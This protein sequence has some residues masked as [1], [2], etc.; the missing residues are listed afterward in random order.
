ML[1]QGVRLPGVMTCIMLYCAVF[2][3]A[4]FG[5]VIESSGETQVQP[6]LLL[7][8]FPGVLAGLTSREAPLGVALCGAV[9]ATPL[10]LLLLHTHFILQSGF[11][12][13]FA[14]HA[15]ALFWCGSGALV[16]MLWRAMFSPR[17]HS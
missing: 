17:R 7:F 10:C 1:L 4:R 3:I 15:S 14:W 11:W 6:G 8:I 2:I 13:E 9:V 12:Q 5:M 16:V